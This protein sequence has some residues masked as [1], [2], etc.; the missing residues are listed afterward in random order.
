M[1]EVPLRMTN[2]QVTFSLG[3][4]WMLAGDEPSE[5]VAETWTGPR[6]GH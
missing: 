2:P 6:G 5:H 1:I 4:T 3:E